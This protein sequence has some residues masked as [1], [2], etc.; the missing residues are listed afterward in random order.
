[1]ETILNRGKNVGSEAFHAFMM[2][3]ASQPNPVDM[4]GAMWIIEGLGERMA[5]GWA[6]R[7]EELCEREGIT[8]FMTYHGANDDDH[9]QRFYAMLDEVCTG[10]E[11]VERIEMTAKVVARLYRL[12]LEEMDDE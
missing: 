6:T 5:T 10:S 7:M 1:L 3:R 2:Q 11:V 8:R 12:Q 4:L 9:M